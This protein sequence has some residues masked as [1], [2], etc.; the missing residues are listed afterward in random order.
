MVHQLTDSV[1]WSQSIK[2]MIEAGVTTFLEIG[3]KN[4]LTGLTKRIDKSV[5]ALSIETLT[6]IENLLEETDD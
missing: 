6:D 3:P 4:I 5:T 1:Q 2:M